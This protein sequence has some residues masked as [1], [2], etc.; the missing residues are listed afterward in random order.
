MRISNAKIYN[1]LILLLTVISVNQWN[2]MFSI[3]QIFS[4]TI[5][6][7]LLAYTIRHMVIAKLPNKKDYIAVSL[8]LAYAL[9]GCIRGV[10]I[11]DDYWTYKQLVSG[12][13]SLSLPL[14]LYPFSSSFITRDFL[15]YWLKYAVPLYFIVFIWV[16]SAGAHHFYLGPI[17][18]LICLFP[19]LPRKWKF[20][21]GFMAIIML[22]SDLGAR[23]QVIKTAVCIL[24]ALGCYFKRFITTSLLRIA[25][26]ICYIVPTVLLTL[27]ILGV[28][29]IFED[30][31]S[32]K[33]KHVSTRVVNGQVK[34]EDL[35]SDTR[36]FIYI[37]TITSA[38]RHNY[39]LF[40]RTPARG[41]DSIVFGNYLGDEL[42][43]GRYERHR[44]EVCHPNVFT[45]IGIIG[46]LLYCLIYLKGSFLALY[47][48]NNFYIKILGVFV[49]FRWAYGWVE[50]INNF[51][52]MSISLWMM[53]A[54]CFSYQFRIMS[55]REFEKWFKSIF[56]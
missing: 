24:V 33:G 49:A 38:I 21:V 42:K 26:W 30:L 39:V 12:T 20:I 50:D 53:I 35:A 16:L 11:A 14:F 45:W 55:N 54:M 34:E 31:S 56:R 10:F 2:K 52:I 8:Y 46:M 47:E 17:F 4:W 28:F 5:S 23:S 15:R 43:T 22:T 29:N 37:E 41:N 7:A 44:N 25:H 36:T 9:V 6:F 19:L 51:S 40:G 18:L 32:N 3:G 13:L 27:G 1:A 48:S